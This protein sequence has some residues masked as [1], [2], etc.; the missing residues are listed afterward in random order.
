MEIQKFSQ[1]F[2]EN[3]RKFSP[4][5]RNIRKFPESFPKKKTLVEIHSR[6]EES[7]HLL[8]GCVGGDFVV[9]NPC[10]ELPSCDQSSRCEVES[11]KHS[12]PGSLSLSTGHLDSHIGLHVG[13]VVVVTYVEHEGQLFVSRAPW[14]SGELFF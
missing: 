5:L 10:R 3:I 13:N 14:L 4:S 2:P 8:D 9:L 12:L 11:S 7:V 1:D 6:G